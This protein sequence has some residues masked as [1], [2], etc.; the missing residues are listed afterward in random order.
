MASAERAEIIID[1]SQFPQGTELYLEN[2]LDQDDGRGPYGDYD[3]PKLR[4]RGVPILKFIVGEAADD[5]G[6][7]PDQLRPFDAIS[8]AERRQAQRH[9]C[10]FERR[11]G[12]WAING[13]FVDIDKR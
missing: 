7:V 3:E 10:K 12:A 11:R 13:K 9:H 6:R 4:D 5:P 2:R 8:S 1:F